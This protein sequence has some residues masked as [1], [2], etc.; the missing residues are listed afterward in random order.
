MHIKPDI[1]LESCVDNKFYLIVCAWFKYKSD[2]QLH[3]HRATSYKDLLQ[4]Q[5]TMDY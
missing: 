3:V 4:T 2:I 1:S 5:L